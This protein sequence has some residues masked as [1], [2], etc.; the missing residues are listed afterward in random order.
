MRL[1]DQ[2]KKAR[3]QDV[4]TFQADINRQNEDLVTTYKNHQLE[5]KADFEMVTALVA[6]QE[7]KWKE[8]Q[9]VQQDAQATLDAA[10]VACREYACHKEEAITESDMSF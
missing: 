4:D 7:K 6:K 8:I 2:F 5:L 10:L 3:Q 1:V 9:E